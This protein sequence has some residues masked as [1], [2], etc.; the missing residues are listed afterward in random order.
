MNPVVQYK[1]S[2]AARYF[3]VHPD[4]IGMKITEAEMYFTSIKYNGHFGMITVKNG[5]AVIY[6]SDGSEKSI[7][8]IETAALKLKKDFTISGEICCFKDGVSQT[9]IHVAAALDEP[10][11]FDLRFAVFD[12]LEWESDNSFDDFTSRYEIM[13]SE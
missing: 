10:H 1:S 5:K 13:K 7:P 4:E 6:G 8:S 9:N 12:I 11:Q 3:P 2:V